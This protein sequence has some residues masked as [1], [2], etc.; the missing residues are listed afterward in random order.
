MVSMLPVGLLLLTVLMCF[1]VI[2]ILYNI[3]EFSETDV[4]TADL[5]GGSQSEMHKHDC[6]VETVYSVTDSQ[7]QAVC[8]PPGV[9]SSRNGACINVLAFG[10][11]DASNKCDPKRGVL[12]FLLGDPQFGDTKMRC[13]SVDPGIQPDDPDGKNVICDHGSIDIDYVKSFPQPADCRCTDP[14]R[15][16]LALVT[17]TKEVRKRGVCVSDKMSPLYRHNDLLYDGSAI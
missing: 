2:F 9:F 5:V 3:R 4:R 8:K 10:T 17:N 13:Y 14:A 16:V 12:A 7:C 15:S 1:V 6:D 11:G